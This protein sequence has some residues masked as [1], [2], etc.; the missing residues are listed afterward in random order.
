[1]GAGEDENSTVDVLPKVLQMKITCK[2]ISTSIAFED[3]FVTLPSNG[4][5]IGFRNKPRKVTDQRWEEIR[6][7]VEGKVFT[8]KNVLHES[9]HNHPQVCLILEPADFR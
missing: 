4:D 2:I 9:G 8:I 5:L 1:M 7:Q 6:Q 3:E